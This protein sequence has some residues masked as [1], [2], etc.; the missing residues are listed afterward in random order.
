MQI[1][2]SEELNKQIE[3]YKGMMEEKEKKI[4]ENNA[5]LAKV[6]KQ[7]ED[8]QEEI[9]KET[10]IDKQM[11]LDEEMNNAKRKK[12]YIESNI[13]KFKDGNR[14]NEQRLKSEIIDKATQEIRKARDEEMIRIVQGIS[15]NAKKQRELATELKQANQAG[16]DAHDELTDLLGNYFEAK[17]GGY[18]RDKT[19]IYS[20]S[21]PNVDTATAEELMKLMRGKA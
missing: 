4:A 15:D 16:F 9:N 7:I 19:Y 2:F 11:K 8:Y 1:K 17:G 21:F 12:S 13:R 6:T 10:D 20:E 3:E 18:V 14:E 5:E